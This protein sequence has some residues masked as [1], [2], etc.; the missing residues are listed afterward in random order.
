MEHVWVEGVIVP[1]I[2][3]VILPLQVSLSGVVEVPRH[4][5]ADVGPEEGSDEVEI[6]VNWSEEL[7]VW[8]VSE[9]FVSL[10]IWEGLAEGYESVESETE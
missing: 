3:E 4:S 7:I 2:V 9:S 1:E 10:G 5:D 8:M 6:A